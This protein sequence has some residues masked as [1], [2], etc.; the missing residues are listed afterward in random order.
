MLLY[1][2]TDRMQLGADERSRREALLKKIAQAAAASV[3]YIQLRERDLT[4]RELERLAAE[5]A[6][7]VRDAGTATKLLVNSRIDVA[8]A[9]GAEGVHLRSDD[10]PASEARAIWAKS[11]E[12]TDAIIAQSCHSLAE[13][14]S[15]ESHGADF[16]VFGPVFGKQ[17]SDQLP[18]GA[19]A[20]ARVVRRGTPADPR[21]EA[22]QTLRMPVI[23]LG[24]VTVENAASCMR[25]GAA[26]VAAIRMFQQGDVAE[27]V[28][29]LRSSS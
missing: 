8:L 12:R 26:G 10:I 14:L 28:R 23:A 25:A 3:D 1:Y 22:G 24:G 9:A 5:A 11:R 15:A 20:L 19:E 2:I 4:A 18:M 7:R 29:R 17:G 6:R 27:V 21:V 13:V 16:V